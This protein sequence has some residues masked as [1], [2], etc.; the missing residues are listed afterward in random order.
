MNKNKV[1]WG[2]VKNPSPLF[3]IFEPSK[4][5]IMQISKELY[6]KPLNLSDEFRNYDI[7]W[8]LISQYFYAGRFNIVYDIGDMRGLLGFTD[9][10]PGFKCDCFFKL[11]DEKLWNAD[12]LRQTKKL[13][14]F[15]MEQF[16][17]KRI[18]TLSADPKVVKMAEKAGFRVE[19]EK[20]NDFMWDKEF[21]TNFY[22]G[23]IREE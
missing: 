16:D 9:I 3:K 12:F 14:R 7:I 2:K 18:N 6:E 22:L 11:F 13:F 19:G 1:D 15:F 21:F 17:L 5:K 4:E 8:A 10:I 23:L 20:P